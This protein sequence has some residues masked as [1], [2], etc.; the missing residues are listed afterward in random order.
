MQRWELCAHTS[1]YI[2][3][4]PLKS[5]SLKS[6]CLFAPNFWILWCG[7]TQG[8]TTKQRG[9]AVDLC[10][11][12]LWCIS[13]AVSSQDLCASRH[14]WRI[15]AWQP[16]PLPVSM[17]HLCWEASVCA[18]GARCHTSALCEHT[19]TWLSSWEALCG[20]WPLS[21]SWRVG[22]RETRSIGE[23]LL[24]WV[25]R[26]VQGPGSVTLSL[27]LTSGWHQL[28]GRLWNVLGL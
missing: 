17:T 1:F 22:N 27:L 20:C 2:S 12:G 3:K 16:V 7:L 19:R 10:M 9:R 23:A 18:A 11:S 24:C 8:C 13:P 4:F 15:G 25:R 6:L 21:Y 26:V 14:S 28:W 5:L